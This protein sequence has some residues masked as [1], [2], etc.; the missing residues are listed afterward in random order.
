MLIQGFGE[1]TAKQEKDSDKL[2]LIKDALVFM[3]VGDDFRIAVAYELLCG[4]KAVDRAI[5]TKEV[6][7]R[8]DLTGAK[9]ISLT[10][11]GLPA[12]ISVAKKLGADWKKNKTHFPRPGC[13]SEKIYI[14][15]DPSH[16]MKLLRKYLAENDLCYEKEELKWDYLKLL[17]DKQDSDNFSITK[18]LTKGTL[19]QSVT[20]LADL[21][22]RSF[23]SVELRL[24]CLCNL[25]SRKNFTFI[26]YY[27][28]LKLIII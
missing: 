18:K 9:V 28:L 15:F 8:I 2:P 12:N 24:H 16:M 7:R 10:S 26:I 11:D 6:I 25:S 14:I 17:A 19:S 3:A 23:S 13:P 20:I 22:I 27:Q 5:L 21:T 1:P 4:M